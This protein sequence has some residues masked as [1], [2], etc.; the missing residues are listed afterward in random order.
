[1][2]AIDSLDRA[3]FRLNSLISQSALDELG[4]LCRHISLAESPVPYQAR[5]TYDLDVLQPHQPTFFLALDDALPAGTSCELY[6]VEVAR[7]Y[8]TRFQIEARR[9]AR[10]YLGH[11]TLRYSRGEVQAVGA[12]YYYNSRDSPTSLVIYGDRTTKQFTPQ[13][14]LPAFHAELRIHGVEALAREGLRG[15]LDLA[16]INFMNIWNRHL[17]FWSLP[18]QT[19]LGRAL[20][21]RSSREDSLQRAARNAIAQDGKC[22]NGTFA[23]QKLVAKRPAIKNV[24]TPLSFREWERAARESALTPSWF[25][26]DRKP[27]V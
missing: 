6:Y 5:W 21:C 22:D 16:K 1:M 17:S 10:H 20:G 25:S 8:V 24:V 11:A 26:S 14:G 13:F 23:L 27:T 12:G 18:S 15:P 2:A 4:F 9:M 7:D 3:R 19:A